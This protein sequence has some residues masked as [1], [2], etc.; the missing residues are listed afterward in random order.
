MSNIIQYSVLKLNYSVFI[1]YLFYGILITIL[2][3]AASYLLVLQKPEVEKLS[4]L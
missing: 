4:A 3:L 2:I 1:T